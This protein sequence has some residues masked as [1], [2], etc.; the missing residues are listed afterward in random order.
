M[1]PSEGVG[2][3]QHQQKQPSFRDLFAFTTWRD[4]WLLIAGLLSSILTGG[5]RTAVTV[6][7]GKI[8]GIISQYGSGK[9]AATDALELVSSWCLLL[10]VTGFGGWLVSFA[11]AVTWSA[12]SEKQARKIRGAMFRGLLQKDM[13]WFDAQPDGIPSLLARIQTQ[14]R[15]LQRASSLTLGNLAVEITTSIANLVV[16]LYLAW[17]ITLVMLASIPIAVLVLR[18]LTREIKPAIESQRQELSQA[19]KYVISAIKAIDLVKVFNGQD[20]ESWQYLG[21]IR[22]SMQRYL[23]QARAN[24][25]Q[26]G[27]VKFWIDCLF[28]GGFFYGTV[29]VDE[30]FTPGNI[31]TAF[32]AALAALQAIQSF[33]PIYLVLVKGMSA[34][35]ALLAVSRQVENGRVVHTMMGGLIPRECRGDIKVQNLTFAYPTTPANTVLDHASFYFRSGQLTFVV[36]RSGSG[37]STLGNLLTKLYEPTGGEILIDDKPIQT[38]NDEWIRR[39][40]TLIQQDSTVFNESLFMN[41]AF[42][43]RNPFLVSTEDVKAACSS[44]LLQSCIANLPDGLYSR[45]GAGAQNLSGGEKQ[46][47]AIARAKLRDSPVLILDEVT[48]GLDP[49]NRVLVLEGIRDWRKG[50]TTIIITHDISQIEKDDWVYAIEDG[51]NIQQGICRDL[52]QWN[53]RFPRMDMPPPPSAT[54]SVC[55][56]DFGFNEPQ[57]YDGR[58]RKSNA[59]V[60]NFSRRSSANLRL[61]SP[62]PGESLFGAPLPEDDIFTRAQK[63][64]RMQS[65]TNSR[66]YN[67]DDKKSLEQM[68]RANPTPPRRRSGVS[69]VVATLSRQLLPLRFTSQQE[70]YDWDPEDRPAS[71]MSPIRTGSLL[72]MQT[73]GQ[74]IRSDRRVSNPDSWNCEE[75]HDR[76]HHTENRRQDHQAE[77]RKSSWQK[78]DK[79]AKEMKTL[80]LI[81]IYKSIWLCLNF[82]ERVFLIV[83]FVMNLI[84]AGSVPAFSYVFANLLAVL[85]EERD[86]RAAGGKWALI[87]LSIAVVGA[88]ATFL[89][90]YLLEWA[91]Q[92]WVNTLRIQS[93]NRV[94]RQPKKW[95]DN[96]RHSADRINECMYLDAEDMRN[97]VGRVAP[98]LI[99]VVVITLSSVIWALAISWK[100]TFVSL[101]S[102]PVLLLATRAHSA[103]SNKWEMRCHEA[104]EKTSSIVVEVFTN[105][106]VVRALTLESYFHA[107]HANAARAAFELGV[108]K[109]GYTAT[110][111]ACWQSIF[112]FM[113]ALIFWYATVLLTVNKEITAQAILQVVNILVLGLTT[114]AN[115]LSSVPGIATAQ[116]TATRLLYFANLP[117]RAETRGTKRL[118]YMFPIQMD[119]MSFAYPSQKG[120]NVLRNVTL[121]FSANSSTA[122]VGP[123]GCGKSTLAS[124]LLGLYLPEPIARFSRRGARYTASQPLTFASSPVQ[125]LDIAH[126]QSHIGYVPQTPF[127]FPATLAENILYGLPEESPLREATNIIRAAKAAGI[128]DFIFTLPEGYETMVGDGG[129]SLSGGQAQRVCIARAIARKPKLLVLDE[130]TSALDAESAQA[131]RDTLRDLQYLPNPDGTRRHTNKMYFPLNSEANICI[132]VITHNK[133]MMQLMDRVVVIDEGRIVQEG[134][135]QDL[136]MRPGKFREITNGGVWAGRRQE[137]MDRFYERWAANP[138]LGINEAIHHEVWADDGGLGGRPPPR[139]SR[140][141]HWL[142]NPFKAQRRTEYDFWGERIENPFVSQPRINREERR[143]ENPFTTQLRIS[144]EEQNRP[145]NPFM[146]SRVSHDEQEQRPENPLAQRG[147]S[148]YGGQSFSN[149]SAVTKPPTSFEE[150]RAAGYLPLRLADDKSEVRETVVTTKTP[151]RAKTLTASNMAATVNTTKAS[152]TTKLYKPPNWNDVDWKGEAGGTSTTGFASPTSPFTQSSRRREH[153]TDDEQGHEE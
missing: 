95:F 21:P 58:K 81:T 79:D 133:H 100:L 139:D 53:G 10:V 130:P 8:F 71:Q 78:D 89:G 104:A 15:E 108:K 91:G 138:D 145:E 114:A 54:A 49:V 16:A 127:L 76:Q 11:F 48:S 40:I 111:Y 84:L 57:G 20:H 90:H 74:A 43:A 36:G 137:S 22:R 44:A 116:T 120:H 99:V 121:T 143:S 38:L 27:F 1:A 146:Q 107:K 3:F 24:G 112:W 61:G 122:I 153:K 34:G 66:F 64:D 113:M 37:K 73:L 13:A 7:I 69:R 72:R 17:K 5:L 65:S 94:L 96:P 12:Y 55:D 93:F 80:S 110:L 32:Y 85:F 134:T 150:M 144:H 136:R 29:L 70:A 102:G 39:Y 86:R 141:D 28:V 18:F 131:I 123:S 14:T 148:N 103:V 92:A 151:K 6:L 51:R 46:R 115:I 19:S 63:M 50:K 26:M 47:L 135:Y 140:D 68:V 60:R 35:Q 126:L 97:L 23:I 45:V 118:Q 52:F 87:L 82:K 147:S 117:V 98:L 128:H 83:G 119:R 109:A 62:T 67:V 105:I 77:I 31:L 30:S 125:Q 149:L 25:Y 132:V 101:A 59:T 75:G 42:G 106:R 41:V 4:A 142:A 124:I 88:I 152:N 9:L 33:V 56:F 129:Q 2:A